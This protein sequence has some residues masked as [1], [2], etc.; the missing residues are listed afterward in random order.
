ML[1]QTACRNHPD[2]P[3]LGSCPSCRTV[4]CEECATRIDGILQCRQCLAA[5]TA[6]PARRA[7]RSRSAVLPALV[8]APVGCLLLAYVLQGAAEAV[9]FLAARWGRG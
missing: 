8:L 5:A 4:V 2:R 3:G 9:A 1:V 6:R 7:W